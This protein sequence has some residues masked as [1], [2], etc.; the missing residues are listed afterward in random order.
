MAATLLYIMRH[1]Q[2]EANAAKHGS[3]IRDPTLTDL[4]RRQAH[5]WA[6]ISA[7]WGL[8]TVYVSPLI[9]TLETAMLAFPRNNVCVMRS[10][11]EHGWSEPQNQGSSFVELEKRLGE[12]NYDCS[13]VCGLHKLA[14]PHIFFDPDGE[15]TLSTDELSRRRKMASRHLRRRVMKLGSGPVALVCHY[16][17]A[18]DLFGV[19]L[20]NA[21]VIRVVI[22]QYK[23]E[24]RTRSL[25]TLE[26]PLLPA[27]VT[28]T[29]A[30]E[31]P[32]LTMADGDSDDESSVAAAAN[33]SG[34]EEDSIAQVDGTPVP[35][36]INDVHIKHASVLLT[37]HSAEHGVAVALL[38]GC[39]GRVAYRYCDFGGGLDGGSARFGGQKNKAMERRHPHLGA[40]RELAEEF[41]GLHGDE[42]RAMAAKV[43]DVATNRLVGGHPV[44]HNQH[45]VFVLPAEV[46]LEV[47]A[48]K[49]IKRSLCKYW[50]GVVGSCRHGDD[51]YWRHDQAAT[52]DPTTEGRI[53]VDALVEY[54]MP[55]SEVS[56][57]KLFPLA[58]L[59]GAAS[60]VD[61]ES[62]TAV[63]VAPIWA[64]KS[65]TG[66]M[67]VYDAEIQQKLEQAARNGDDSGVSVT[68]RSRR[69]HVATIFP[70]SLRHCGG[71]RPDVP[72]DVMRWEDARLRPAMVGPNGS[73]ASCSH[74]LASI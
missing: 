46:L 33:S 32:L 12:L 28:S 39:H 34:D 51:C 21:E 63:A 57:V 30:R 4:G 74:V 48:A 5:S 3:R 61:E 7:A 40:F 65:L 22:E 62:G 66:R 37:G 42:A 18:K 50:T 72:L 71:R 29:S 10:L 70:I 68:I 20:S 55:N 47:L 67:S 45:L 13:L 36:A 53:G 6:E 56:D 9:R 38:G 58:S 23:N 59:L 27:A 24:W 26:M 44:Q 31:T 64:W 1:G 17:T 35:P 15:P 69:P 8:Q 43:W 41:L 25:E 14:K 19:R 54:F 49:P 73:L 2:S 52:P 11:R 60:K 16:V